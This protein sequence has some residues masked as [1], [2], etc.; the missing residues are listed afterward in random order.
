MLE[1]TYVVPTDSYLIGA[2]MAA[3]TTEL[4][5]AREILLEFEVSDLL[6][7]SDEQL[8]TIVAGAEALARA[9]SAIQVAGAAELAERSR[10]ELGTAGLAQKHGCSTPT[11]FLEGLARISGA[12]AGRRIH[13][14][15]ALRST[16]GLTGTQLAPRLPVLAAAVQAGAVGPEAALVIVRALDD[17]RRVAI[18]GDL[19]VAEAGLVRH[20]EQHRVQYVSDLA[21][22]VRDRLDP[23]GVLPREEETRARR[24]VQLGRERNGIVPIRGGLAPTTA[25]LLKAVFDEA[26][27]PGARP[28]FLSEDDRENGTITT[29]NED[30]EEVVTIRDLRTRDQRQHDVFDGLLK[31]GV[32]NTGLESGQIRSTAEVTAHISIA[33][34]ESGIGVGWIDGIKES[35]SVNTIQRL[36][37]DAIFRRAVL[38]NDGEVLAFGKARYP[39]TSAQ[40]KAIIARDGDTCLLCDAPVAWADAHHVQE[41][42][43]HGAVGETNV[44]N[45]VLLCQRD[46]DLIHHTRWQITMINGIPHVLAPPEIDPGQT[47][48]RVGRPRVQFRR[49]G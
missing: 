39:F 45:G 20:A 24:G 28:R 41:Y 14:G 13:L 31:A 11:A 6:T 12:E 35:V 49:T 34:L 48:K 17:V 5:A 2:T 25:A 18:P 22:V 27:A 3:N 7:A 29:V 19:L 42:Y 26:N 38:G 10:R 47:W 15:S 37:C 36:L 8:C 40:R 21:T 32:R 44:D 33:D 16:I 9:V 23:D 46:H 1:Y 4:E 43:T 30:G